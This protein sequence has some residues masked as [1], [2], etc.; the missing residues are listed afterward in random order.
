MIVAP[1]STMA[2][3]RSRGSQPPIGRSSFGWIVLHDLPER[4]WS[5]R[6]ADAD[7]KILYQFV[8]GRLR[9]KLDQGIS[10]RFGAV[11][12]CPACAPDPGGRGH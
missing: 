1:T 8:C 2:K 10:A 6:P 11:A 5:R 4:I 9:I 7:G 12:I 3:A